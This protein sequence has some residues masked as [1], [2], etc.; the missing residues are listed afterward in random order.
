MADNQQSP[1]YNIA[2]AILGLNTDSIPE[3]IKEGQLTYALNALIEN[4][5][6]D[7][8]SYGNEQ[9]TIDCLKFPSGYKVI[10]AKNITAT[11]RVVFMLTNPETGDSEIG[12]HDNET[13]IYNTL[14][15]DAGSVQKFNFSIDHPIQK[16]VV[17]ITN[18]S[19]QIYWTDGY[20][21]RRWMDMD[22][23]P[24]K[25][26]KNPA[27]DYKPIKV[28]GQ[29]DAN[30]LLIEPVFSI[31]SIKATSVD[32][33]GETVMGT[34]Q[35]AAQY[36][37]SLGDG[38]TSYYNVTNPISIYENTVSP[39][40]NL[41]T[42]K[43]INI[44][45]SGLDTSGVWDYFN[46]AVVKT[47]N[48]TSTVELVGT[49]PI[50]ESTYDYNYTGTT[51]DAVQLS[52][53]DIFEKFPYY[54]VAQDITDVD[55]V[56]VWANLTKKERL[57]YQQIWRNVKA[58]WEIWQVPYN[59][60]EG[61][62]NGANTANIRGY[63]RDEV[64]ALEG[65][66][67]LD[68]GEQTDSFPLVGREANENDRERVYNDDA[69]SI[70]QDKCDE[71]DYKERWQVY[72]T[73]SLIGYS[74]E[75][76]NKVVGDDCYVGPYQYG[77][78]AYWESEELYPNNQD[79]WGDLSNT[80]IRHFK[81]PDATIT[82]I[83]DN[84]A[85]G[86]KAFEHKIY[87]IGIKIDANSLYYAIQASSLTDEEKARIKGFKVVRGNRANNKS[88]VAKGLL[89]NVGKY[90][91]IP[92]TNDTTTQTFY[93]AN[94]PFN[95]LRPDPYFVTK[96]LTDH[97]GYRA[98][99]SLNGFGDDSKSRFVFHSPDTHFYQ[100]FGIDGG[101]LKL[102]T[103]EYGES[104]GHFVKVNKNA[105]YK[106]LT[107]STKYAAAGIAA[108][109]SLNL[110]AGTFGWPT[111]SL[112][113]VIPS[114]QAAVDL[115]E[116][117]I[118]YTN[119]GYSFNSTGFYNKS[120]VIPNEGNKVRDINFGKYVIDGR[121]SIEIPNNINNFRRE[122]AVYLN[123]RSNFL[124]PNEYSPSVP[125]DN[126][127]YNLTSGQINPI[128]LTEYLS[129]LQSGIKTVLDDTIKQVV[130]IYTSTEEV[131]ATAT[132]KIG[133]M[134]TNQIPSV[135]DI[136]IVN[137]QNY[138]ITDV[139]FFTLSPTQ[140]KVILTTKINNYS[141]GTFT[142]PPAFS[143]TLDLSYKSD[144]DN[145]SATS[146]D[147]D[148]VIYVLPSNNNAVGD[149]RNNINT[150]LATSPTIDDFNALLNSTL[151][152]QL[153]YYSISYEFAKEL[154]ANGKIL[155]PDTIRQSSISSYY[156][157]IKKYLPNQWG[158]IH[159]Y[160]V[161]DTGFYSDLYN[162]NNESFTS[163]PTVFGGDIFINRF[164]YKSKVQ[165]FL[166]TTWNRPNQA[167]IE[168]D[169]LG[170]YGYPMFWLSTRPRNLT[171]DI[172]EN[173]DKVI[174]VF[175][176]SPGVKGGSTLGKIWTT[177]KGII[178]GGFA[179]TISV[180]GLIFKIFQE[181]YTK[182]GIANINFDNYKAD[183][184]ME[185]GVMYLYSYGVPYFFVESEVNVDYRQAY[186]NTEGNFYPNVGGD[187]PDQWLQEEEVPIIQDNTYTYN[188][189]YSKQNKENFF[190]H[191]REDYDPKKL[192]FTNF[193]NRAIYSDKSTLE[194]TKNNW[195]V[196]R[197]LS[198][199]DFPKSNGPLI[200]LDKLETRQV[201][202]RFENR[203]QIYNALLTIDVG[204]TFSAYAGSPSLFGQA[205]PLDIAETDIG[206]AGSQHKFLLKTEYGH[207]FI[208]ATRG[209]IILLQGTNIKDIADNGMDKWFS[210]NLPFN[211][212]K[213]FP[214]V[215]IDNAFKDIGLHG[216][217]DMFYKRLIITKL[218]Y[219]PLDE[220]IK[221]V[222]GKF[223]LNNKEISLSDEKYFCN[224][225][226][227][228][229]YSFKTNS[230]ISF[231]SYIPNYYVAYPNYFQS[232]VNDREEL[233]SHNKTFFS[234]QNFYGTQYPYI[235]EYPFAYK[236]NDEIVQNIKEYCT[237]RKYESYDTYYEPS[238][239]IFYN[240]AILYSTQQCTGVLNL[241][242]KPIN[243][244]ST[245]FAYPKY[246]S[247]SKDIL[248][249]KSD[250]FYNYNTFWNI[251]TNE[252]ASFFTPSCHLF[253]VDKELNEDNLDYTQ[254][255]YKKGMMRGK[256]LRVRHILDN[257][258][259][260]KLISHFIVNNTTDSY[261]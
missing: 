148:S 222:D 14:I 111:M 133:S 157:A 225:S 104:Y 258:N 30:K 95:D 5:N 115:F 135:G 216:V 186:N 257:R 201:L 62:N 179:N 127:R 166:N 163:F 129:E 52:I 66:F 237:V 68:N 34:Y 57:N 162:S 250:N 164:A 92:D 105:E 58:Y 99:I 40:F 74:D 98:D 121:D 197:P 147:Y 155:Q 152:D 165:M 146:I 78:F 244:L 205:P 182:V 102:E 94:Y 256:Q 161:I 49:F 73:A 63:M 84:N 51:K 6:G 145:N 171:I 113:P 245:R 26:E 9:S 215:N 3:Q 187:I 76:L 178:S 143:G 132:F 233:F 138:E 126:S 12:I 87:P 77:E 175:T 209:Q 4:F 79:I 19:T 86:D 125:E 103:I 210:E 110:A 120:Y 170:M 226:W 46:L 131:V 35:F 189:T 169:L 149:V 61:Y 144:V 22:E 151:N 25:E 260:V 227:T 231:H 168:Y 27:N 248:V 195:L 118:P 24:W 137:S 20:N 211:I 181:I 204:S 32:I 100:P 55:N 91:Y 33:G 54:D 89:H 45:I 56:L 173:I 38:Y 190:S 130:S 124:Y 183:G 42:S 238:E 242:P 223:L 88:I 180:F 31:P 142:P 134:A 208:D 122:S 217:Y 28:V 235:L 255:S 252:N 23:L 53:A 7:T 101:Q 108:A 83:H 29:L 59:R 13:C 224:K 247:N 253:L 239:L 176:N 240:K 213:A 107:P 1:K 198:Y 207:V 202:A 159:S 16:I 214:T 43:S 41:P 60:F 156:G 259:D 141:S 218:D 116:K 69:K 192:C 93:Y 2:T 199:F 206:Y 21:P 232:G 254:R 230:W 48:N 249:S 150:F 50:I 44:H 153:V 109:S 71:V 47:I 90:T 236:Y 140:S 261:K 243:N 80:P 8:I 112:E 65:C 191:L 128:T 184:I 119:F 251:N 64:Y 75:F 37:N 196:Y 219:S 123:T 117:L 241:I 160:E 167:D 72:N 17:K 158:R 200:S 96:R 228:I 188:K 114:Y 172:Q 81:F 67:I 229:S 220:N 246:N 154:S 136:Y 106:F 212:L 15:S 203:S 177:I 82:T 18:C 194:E 185:T 36:S 174:K 193:P 234:F 11:N 70:T 85:S 221:Y 97:I 10:G 139:E 39:N